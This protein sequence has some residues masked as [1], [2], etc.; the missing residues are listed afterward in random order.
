MAATSLVKPYRVLPLVPTRILPTAASATLTAIVVAG[1]GADAVDAGGAAAGVASWLPPPQAASPTAASA[2][3]PMRGLRFMGRESFRGRGAVN[4][5]QRPVRPASPSGS[6]GA[7][8][9]SK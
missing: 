7:G 9:T 6:R 8:S 1:A 2:A 4:G 5:G 3:S